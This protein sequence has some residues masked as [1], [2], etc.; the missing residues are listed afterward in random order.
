LFAGLPAFQACLALKLH[1]NKWLRSISALIAMSVGA[2]FLAHQ[3]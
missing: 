1:L 2:L 3:A